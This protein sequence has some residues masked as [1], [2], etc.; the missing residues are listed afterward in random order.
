MDVATAAI[1]AQH[2]SSTASGSRTSG[3]ARHFSDPYWLAGLFFVAYTALSV[4]RFRRL[5]AT[6]WDLGIFEQAIRAYANFQ[7]PVADL[8][9][10]GF[11]ILGDHFSP[12]TML[13]APFYKVFPT[14]VTLL[15]VQA[16]LF[17]IS[18]V[19]IVRTAGHI[20]GRSQALAIGVAYGLSWGVQRAVAFDFHEIAFAMPLLAFSLAAVLRKRWKTAMWWALPLVLVKEDLGVTLAAIGLVILI[21]VRRG[22]PRLVPWAIGLIGF[23]LVFA[24]LTFGVIIPAFN[25]AGGYDYWNKLSTDGTAA[26]SQTIP[27]DTALRTLLWIILP[28]SGLLALRSPL[29]LVAAP[30]IGWRFLGH[31]DHYWGLDWHYSAVLMPV[32]LLALVDAVDRS[33][34]SPRSWLRCYG[35]QL[36]T[37]VAGA[38]LALSAYLPLADLTHAETYQRGERAEAIAELFEQTIP[39]G[40]TVEA[41]VGPISLL[42]SRC[43]VFWLGNVPRLEPDF[44]A[45]DTAT[46]NIP[47]G[48]VYAKG[49]HPEATYTEVANVEGYFILRRT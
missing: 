6:T 26:G 10:Q 45:Y 21:R 4:C 36:P 42:T 48:V 15:V 44:I 33:R 41:N 16:A 7:A 49:I 46:F 8:K 28:T 12:I 29:L 2:G 5:G 40:A 20:L 27:L 30:T 31:D 25:S 37:A 22:E 24:V 19:P 35:T 17:A 11:N 14:P 9:G 39:D 43:Q 32:L 13:V 34:H 47:S 1:P 3:T 18:V 23:G 38:A